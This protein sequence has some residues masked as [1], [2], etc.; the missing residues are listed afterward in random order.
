MTVV[1]ANQCFHE[2]GI[3]IGTNFSVS[4]L[5]NNYTGNCRVLLLIFLSGSCNECRSF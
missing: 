3:N 5:K 2:L 1:D 4:I